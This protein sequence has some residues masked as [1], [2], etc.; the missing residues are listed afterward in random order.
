MQI[1]KNTSLSSSRSFKEHNPH[2]STRTEQ[3]RKLSPQKQIL[4][5]KQEIKVLSSSQD[6]SLHNAPQPEVDKENEYDFMLHC[7]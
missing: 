3:V 1:N 6:L 7:H 5:N 2:P 4:K